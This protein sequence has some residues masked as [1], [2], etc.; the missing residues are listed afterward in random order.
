MAYNIQRIILINNNNNKLEVMELKEAV[1]LLNRP[2]LAR[3][4]M[5]K[6]ETLFK[7]NIRLKHQVQLDKMETR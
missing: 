4:N 2:M 7:R 5:T 3:L 1:I 6:M